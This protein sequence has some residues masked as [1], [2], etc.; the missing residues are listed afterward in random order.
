MG[1]DGMKG[2]AIKET[3]VFGL[4]PNWLNGGVIAKIEDRVWGEK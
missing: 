2:G 3:L 1:L 4:S